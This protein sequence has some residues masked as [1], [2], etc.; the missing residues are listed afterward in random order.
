MKLAMVYN[1]KDHKL[2]PDTYSCVY[3]DMFQAV[4]KRFSP[5]Y[6]VNSDCSAKDIEADIILFW[7]VNS[8]HHI[9][10]DGIREHKA[11][12]IEY[13]SDPHQKETKG[14]YQKYNMYVH[15]LG[16]EQR[17]NRARIRGTK[18][19]ISPVKDAFYKYFAP[20]M[21]AEQ[22]LWYFP[23][24][25]AFESC[26]IPLL[27][28]KQ[29]ILAN[30]AYWG[31]E[32]IGAYEFRKWAFQQPSVS[33]IEHSI[34]NDT[35]PNGAN[36]IQLL[37]QYAG[38]LALCDVFPVVKYFEM[39][40]AGMVTFVQYHREYEELGFVNFKNCIYVTQSN[41][42]KRIKDFKEHIQEYQNVATSGRKLME[43]NYTS[44]HFAEFLYQRCEK[45]CLTIQ[46]N[47]RKALL[48]NQ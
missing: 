32:D 28:R 4:L 40:L 47:Q 3:R 33:F 25:P 16:A 12:K 13:W 30:G 43:Y 18:Y 1:K 20:L 27:E 46:R 48:V 5:I 19:I 36:Y 7:D 23:L 9:R 38:G 34:K 37:K 44:K 35:T 11:L 10:I 26:S 17:A 22:M 24:A 6:H 15:K 14:I 42:E 39:P 8:C 2:L 45:E 29:E 31:G 21:N 41:F